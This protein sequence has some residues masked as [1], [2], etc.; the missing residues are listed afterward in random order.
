MSLNWHSNMRI[1]ASSR[2]TIGD[3]V[4]SDIN[5]FD[6]RTFHSFPPEIFKLHFFLFSK[7]PTSMMILSHLPTSCSLPTHDDVRAPSTPLS[8]HII[9]AVIVLQPVISD[10]IPQAMTRDQIKSTTKY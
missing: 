2:L 8:P 10:D 7:K 6:D 5:R 3:E 4:L 1:T 9:H